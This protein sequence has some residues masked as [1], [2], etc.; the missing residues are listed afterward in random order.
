MGPWCCGTCRFTVKLAARMVLSWGC[1]G[2]SP[3]PFLADI[4]PCGPTFWMCLC[5]LGPCETGFGRDRCICCRSCIPTSLGLCHLLPHPHGSTIPSHIPVLPHL[6][7]SS[8]PSH[9]CGSIIPFHIIAALSPSPYHC[10][11]ITPPPSLQLHHLSLHLCDSILPSLWLHHPSSHP[12]S[13]IVP[14]L[15][16]ST[17]LSIPSSL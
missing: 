14:L 17:A 3:C 9:P 10:S 5:F 13:S 8:I 7:G 15:C 4:C 2:S 12:C 16:S 11:A 1:R 6:S